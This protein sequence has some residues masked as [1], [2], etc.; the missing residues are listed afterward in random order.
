MSPGYDAIVVGARCAGSPTAMLLARKG[1]RVLLLDRAT[2]PSDTMSTHIIH[3]PGVAAL[4]RWGLL[5]RLRAT[6][7][8]PMPTYSFDFGP[9]A[10]AGSP[11]GTS[12]A[13]CPRRIVLDQ[14]LVEAAVEAGAELREGF[15]VEEVLQ[16]D[17]RVTGI[18]GQVKG[19]MTLSER[20]RMVV[21]AD[22]RRSLVA[23]AVRA[24]RY[25]E[26][27][28][29][30]AGYYAYWSDLPVEG[31]EA[32]VRP[33]RAFGAAPTNGGLTML[34]M[35][36]PVSEFDANRTDVEASFLGSL[37]LAPGF[38]E[39]VRGATRQTRIAGTADLPNFFRTPYGAGWAL[40]GD[41]GYHKDPITAQGISDAFRDAE[42]LAAALDDALS[43][44]RAY[45]AAM[46]GYHRARDEA[47][48][49]MYELTCD[50]A[51]LEPP[52]PEMR[53]LLGA[54]QT[55]QA[56]MD[57]FVSVMAGALSPSEV[58]GPRPTNGS[59]TTRAAVSGAHLDPE[60]L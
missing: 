17:G 1:Y 23:K 46:A 3:P 15:T 28:P 13:R 52:A 56:A 8:P 29:L 50:F 35:A 7:C 55:D 31:F 9:F 59:R 45:D 27:P 40:V 21:G 16:E 41:A 32:Y 36:W 43:G 19:G 34:V 14:L 39:R 11:R 42:A 37:D 12:P 60:H 2:F 30:A 25:H 18:R 58:F 54:I 44:R 4:E 6:G 57:D 51:R 47:S 38:A 20:A 22:G 49:P 26:R 48:M 5:E 10:I 24:T 33:D 53:Q